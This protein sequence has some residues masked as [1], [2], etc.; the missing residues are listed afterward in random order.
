[1]SIWTRSARAGFR[2]AVVA[3]GQ[4]NNIDVSPSY[5]VEGIQRGFFVYVSLG[6]LESLDCCAMTIF[7]WRCHIPK[8][9]ITHLFD[10]LVSSDIKS[11]KNLTLYSVFA[12]QSSSSRNMEHICISKRCNASLPPGALTSNVIISL[13]SRIFKNFAKDSYETLHMYWIR[14]DKLIYGV[15]FLFNEKYKQCWYCVTSV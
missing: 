5:Y 2:L 9:K 10:V 11:S 4:L 15:F 3:K 14:H 13:A 12:R 7:L 1:M 6:K 8:F